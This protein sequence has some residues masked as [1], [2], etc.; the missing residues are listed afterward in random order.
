MAASS[1]SKPTWGDHIA[2]TPPDMQNLQV[3]WSRLFDE[4]EE[5]GRLVVIRFFTDFPESKRY[6]KTVP[7]EGDL[8]RNPQVA[9]HGR[10][11]M[12]TFNQVIENIENWPNAQKLLQRL[13]DSHKNTHKVPPAMFQRMFRAMLSVCQ[14]I[15]GKDLTNAMLVSWDKFFEIV[16]EEIAVAYGRKRLL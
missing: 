1:S 12:A 8:H 13:V 5:N 4:A 9:L 2:L 14:D 11:V 16:Y 15:M 3:L 7:T 6:F 10:R